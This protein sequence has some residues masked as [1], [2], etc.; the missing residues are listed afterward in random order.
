VA[1]NAALRARLAREVAGEFG[2]SA[3]P[4]LLPALELCTDNAAMVA[5]AAFWA[6]REGRQSGWDADIH[7]RL[8]LGAA[9]LSDR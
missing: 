9:T 3:P 5:G 1:A 8:P 4:L 7:P 2:A 6:L